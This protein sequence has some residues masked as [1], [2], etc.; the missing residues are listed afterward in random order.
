EPGGRNG[1]WV[2]CK[3]E[4]T[5]RFLV[6]GYVPGSH[7][8]DELILGERQ[9]GSLRFV[10]RLKAGFV[11]ATRRTMMNA[12]KPL[13]QDKCPF[14][15][16]PEAGKGRWGEGLDAEAMKKCRWVKPKVA[17]EVAFVEWTEGRKLRHAR[18]VGM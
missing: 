3:A 16:L 4:L 6:G 13:V 2:K 14:V 12:I 17:V 10:S 8:F 7:G 5:G 11:P 1:A 9:G 18:F 15:N